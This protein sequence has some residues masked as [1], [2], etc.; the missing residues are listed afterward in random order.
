MSSK[1]KIT[2][3]AEANV[4]DLHDLRISKDFLNKTPKA[5]KKKL[6]NWTSLKVRTYVSVT[7]IKRMKRQARVGRQ[8]L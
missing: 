2:K 1:F 7:K 8:Y 3:L 5:R 6:I 4:R